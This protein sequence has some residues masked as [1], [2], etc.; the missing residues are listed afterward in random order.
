MYRSAEELTSAA[1]DIYQK[2]S[3]LASQ[4]KLT[5]REAENGAIETT[6]ILT[7][8][9]L[10]LADVLYANYSKWSRIVVAF[11]RRC[12]EHVAED[13]EESSRQL[14]SYFRFQRYGTDIDHSTW[15]SVFFYES[16]QIIARQLEIIKDNSDEFSWSHERANNFSDLDLDFSRNGSSYSLEARSPLG[17]SSSLMS[18]PFDDR[19]IENFVLKH[20]SPRGAVRRVVPANLEP[21]TRFGGELFT[22]LIVD[23]V[24]DL[25]NSVRA[26]AQASN[27]GIRIR[28]R[29]SKA[30]ELSRIPW[31]FIFDGTD[32]LCL[33]SKVTLVRHLDSRQVPPPLELDLP[34]R[35]LVTVSSPDDL[36][37]LDVSLEVERLKKALDPY[38]EMG[39]IELSFTR[40]GEISTLQRILSSAERARRPFHIWHFIGHGFFDEVQTM[41]YLA[42]EAGNSSRRVSGFELAT[43]FRNYGSLRLI[44]LNACETGMSDDIN[45][46]SGIAGSL[47]ERS[48][49]TVV[50]MQ[51]PISDGAAITF[52]SEFYSSIASGA[53]AD[54][55]LV[56]ARRAIFFAPN[57]SEWATP[58]LFTR[59]PSCEVFAVRP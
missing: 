43:L 22:S 48:T 36:S 17:T 1:K 40:D 57:H 53:P 46:M 49:S 15:K 39:L 18:I 9:E 21:F 7:S 19:D 59:S 51:F 24:R 16:G 29:H 20:C 25:Y 35:I 13:F 2:L 42:F 32:F 54:A 45:T 41:G 34:L 47:V 50:A 12:S 8:S 6:P 28:L 26:H 52:A 37:S 11:L 33:D 44:V 56:D 4:V 30:P 31:E 23:E 14:E 38:I 5:D 27:S 55:S 10:K 3:Q 58:V